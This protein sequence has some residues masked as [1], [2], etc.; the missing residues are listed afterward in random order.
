MNQV[1]IPTRAQPL[2]VQAKSTA[3]VVVDMQNDFCLAE[4]AFAKGGRDVSQFIAAIAPVAKLVTR[5]REAGAHVV[6]TRILWEGGRSPRSAPDA[7]KPRLSMGVDR[8]IAVGSW[9]GDIVDQLKPRANEPVI[10]K[11]GLSA[12]FRTTL[13]EELQRRNI[14]TLIMTGVVTYACVLATSLAARDHGFNVV[15]ARDCVGSFFDELN[16]PVFQITDLL[17]GYAVEAEAIAFE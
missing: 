5:G 14:K 6:F 11:Q 15:M 17:L 4:G 13:H 9:G 10:D 16:G 3:I 2:R 8:A 7:I 12:F 1:A